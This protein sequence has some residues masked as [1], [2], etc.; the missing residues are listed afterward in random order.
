MREP[1][2][3][4]KFEDVFPRAIK[5]ISG[6]LGLDLEGTDVHLVPGDRLQHLELRAFDVETEEVHRGV[7]E[8]Q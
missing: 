4:E 6:K 7:A 3:C 2:T 5:D 8:R 1:N